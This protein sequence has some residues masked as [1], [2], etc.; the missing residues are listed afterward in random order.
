MRKLS[1]DLLGKV[2]ERYLNAAKLDLNVSKI[3]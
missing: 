2:S 1:I 3:V